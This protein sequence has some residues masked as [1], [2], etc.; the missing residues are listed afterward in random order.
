M[1][2]KAFSSADI[3]LFKLNNKHIKNL[4][5]NI[6]H[7]LPSETICRKTVLQLSADELERIRN[8]DHEK[9]IFLVAD[10][11]TLSG[12]P[13]LNILVGSLETSH[14][15]YWNDCQPLPYA[16]NSNIIAQAF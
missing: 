13:Y 14:L 7:S 5:H 2:N 6:G 10:E 9:Q 15:S 11:S 3:P 4:F 8:D 1:V 16:P 12:I